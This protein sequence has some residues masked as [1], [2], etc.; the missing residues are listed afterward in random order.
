M[1]CL[2]QI[3]LVILGLIILKNALVAVLFY[4]EIKT[5]QKRDPAAKSFL[6]VLILYQGLHALV[7]YR[8]AHF[9][10]RIRFFFL[11]RFI[12]Q[13]A[14]WATGIE[15]HPGAQIGKG[16]F[17]DHGMGVVIGETAIIGDDVL[18]YQ[19]VTLG[20]TGLEHGKRHPTIGNN[21]VIGAGAKVLGNI[22]IGD[23]SYIGANAV[24]IKDV[25][26]NSTVV[27]VPGRITKQDG[28]KIDISLD[29]IHVLDP[30][31]QSIEELEKR[32]DKLEK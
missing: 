7:A 1:A 6:E 25:P 12:S 16:L 8:S 4:H 15:I 20:G 30:I 31:M 13:V 2:V 5:A 9:F 11:A 14:R 28:K 27:G 32:I 18:L 19:G 23:N 21:V 22:T 10:Y 29:H 3:L 17:I 26:A 24:V